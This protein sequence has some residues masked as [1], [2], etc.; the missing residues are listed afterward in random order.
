MI[1]FFRFLVVISLVLVPWISAVVKKP[2]HS[3]QPF[4]HPKLY[5]GS[6]KKK[7]KKNS[8]NLANTIVE[9]ESLTSELKQHNTD[10]VGLRRKIS[11]VTRDC[12]WLSNSSVASSSLHL[13]NSIV[14]VEPSQRELQLLLLSTL[15]QL[16]KDSYFQFVSSMSR[17]QAM[18][19]LHVS[20][21]CFFL[22]CDDDVIYY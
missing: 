1:M 21:V 20:K 8:F 22:I 18:Y 6:H 3:S 19:Y 13:T 17:K 15:G 16:I 5:E 7:I 10:V 2:T 14:E 12:W 11:M 4:L 9:L